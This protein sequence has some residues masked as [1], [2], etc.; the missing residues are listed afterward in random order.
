MKVCKF[1][2]LYLIIFPIAVLVG[3]WA[4]FCTVLDHIIE[5]YKIK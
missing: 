4:V 5:E 1:I 3:L 2:K